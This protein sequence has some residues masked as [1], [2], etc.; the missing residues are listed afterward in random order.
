MFELIK[1]NRGLNTIDSLF[2]DFLNDGFFNPNNTNTIDYYYS[3]DEKNHYIELALPG[4]DKKDINL[5]ISDG[6]LDLSYESKDKSSSAFWQRS[7]HRRIK[8]PNN[9]NLDSINADLKN[10]ILSIKIGKD[11]KDIANKTI[12]IN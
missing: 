2:N 5:S 1:K 8:L 7:F 9:I 3:N 12:I 11:K 10:G 4:L 6:Y